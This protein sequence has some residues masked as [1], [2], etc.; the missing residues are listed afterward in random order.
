MS[1]TSSSG[2]PPKQYVSQS[3]RAPTPGK[4]T[5]LALGKALPSQILPQD[6]LVEG[7]FRDTKCEDSAIKEKLERLCKRNTFHQCFEISEFGC[8]IRLFLS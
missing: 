7:Y 8:N 5:V 6:C 2:A 3:K 4:A 1:K